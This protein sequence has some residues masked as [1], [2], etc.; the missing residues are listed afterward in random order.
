M[1]TGVAELIGLVITK[2][3]KHKDSEWRKK[4]ELSEQKV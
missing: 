4:N 2:M 3:V 1:N